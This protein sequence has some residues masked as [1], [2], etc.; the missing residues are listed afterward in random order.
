MPDLN[1][2][3]FLLST[4]TVVLYAM[5]GVAQTAS[6]SCKPSGPGE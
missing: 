3:A 2:L 1:K 4:A 6:D 5:T